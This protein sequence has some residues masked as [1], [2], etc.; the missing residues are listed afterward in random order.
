VP[1]TNKRQIHKV[2]A[3]QR[4]L[5]NNIL[6]DHLAYGHAGGFDNGL[7]AFDGHHGSDGA[8]H[9]KTEIL[10]GVLADL[11]RQ[12][13]GNLGGEALHLHLDTVAAGR[14]RRHLVVTRGIGLRGSFDTQGLTLDDYLRARH[15]RPAGVCNRAFDAGGGLRQGSGAAHSDQENAEQNHPRNAASQD[16]GPDLKVHVFSL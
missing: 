10:N 2:A 3:V 6:V 15:G 9:P 11:Q 5:L 7:R 1:G 14:Q 8:G 12:G 16:D 13:I 4:N